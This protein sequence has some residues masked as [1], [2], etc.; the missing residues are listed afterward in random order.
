MYYNEDY[1]SDL[2]MEKNASL[3]LAEITSS[4]LLKIAEDYDAYP[5]EVLFQ[6]GLEKAASYADD[7]LDYLGDLEEQG[8]T[9]DE[10]GNEV[11][12]EEYYEEKTASYDVSDAIIEEARRKL[13]YGE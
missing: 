4:E 13:Y 6:L 8:Y 3:E 9:L 2:I 7:L 10:D 5:E 1:I 11:P 12:M